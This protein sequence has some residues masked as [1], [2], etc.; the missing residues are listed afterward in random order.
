VIESKSKIKIKSEKRLE[1]W[2]ETTDA[3]VELSCADMNLDTSTWTPVTGATPTSISIATVQS[4]GKVPSHNNNNNTSRACGDHGDLREGPAIAIDATVTTTAAVAKEEGMEEDGFMDAKQRQRYK[5]SLKRRAYNEAEKCRFVKRFLEGKKAGKYKSQRQFFEHPDQH[6]ITCVNRS[7]FR[8]WVVDYQKGAID[9]TSTA[10]KRRPGS[11]PLTEKKLLEFLFHHKI[12]CTN[13]EGDDVGLKWSYIKFKALE[14]NAQVEGENDFHCTPGWLSRILKRF[15][16]EW[17][18]YSEAKKN[19]RSDS[20][21]PLV[22]YGKKTRKVYSQAEKYR[23]VSDYLKAKED[24]T[25]TS[26]IEYLKNGST[27]IK[28]LPIGCFRRWMS[29][30]KKGKIHQT[31]NRKR[32]R[33]SAYP[34]TED[35][36]VNYLRDVVKKHG[37]YNMHWRDMSDLAIRFN[38]KIDGEDGF[39]GSSGWID[40]VLR[41]NGFPAVKGSV[42]PEDDLDSGEDDRRRDDSKSES[43]D[44]TKTHNVMPVATQI[45][46]QPVLTNEEFNF[47]EITEI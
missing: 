5:A 12:H 34:K 1:G 27:E 46:T 4:N 43:V 38:K 8:R 22:V 30:Y 15:K 40:K 13:A 24:G 39:K 23:Y 36:L 16:N 47:P 11:F 9:E 19:L 41:R 21:Q 26:T 10:M 7:M 3:A 32:N 14:L 31:S 18:E 37:S 28:N 42:R 44:V 2:R 45:E 33:G 17:K 6:D 25:F 29:E 20:K 35:M